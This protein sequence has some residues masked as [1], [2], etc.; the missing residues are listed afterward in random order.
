MHSRNLPTHW[1]DAILETISQHERIEAGEE[2]KVEIV[3]EEKIGAISGSA[4]VGEVV[5]DPWALEEAG[6]AMEERE[7]AWE[8][9][10]VEEG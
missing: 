4:N 3:V 10:A 9:A 8:G 5:P 7:G 2:G 6:M 1:Q